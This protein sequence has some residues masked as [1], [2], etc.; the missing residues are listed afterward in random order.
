VQVLVNNNKLAHTLQQQDRLYTYNV[1]LRH[2]HKITV[3][4]EEQ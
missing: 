4:V 2:V 3:A 1:S